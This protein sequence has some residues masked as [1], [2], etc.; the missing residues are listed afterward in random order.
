MQS[1]KTEQYHKKTAYFGEVKL[2]L[3]HLDGSSPCPVRALANGF[4]NS[5]GENE[6]IRIQTGNPSR[7]GWRSIV[8]EADAML[9]LEDF[10]EVDAFKEV[11]TPPIVDAEPSVNRSVMML[12]VKDPSLEIVLGK[13]HSYQR[14]TE[15][16]ATS[17]YEDMYIEIFPIES[18]QFLLESLEEECEVKLIQKNVYPLRRLRI[19]RPKLML[20]RQVLSDDEQKILKKLEEA[21]WYEYPRPPGVS[22]ASIAEQLNISGSTLSIQRRAI[23]RKLSMQYFSD[24][25]R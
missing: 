18:L 10:E 21:G 6:T 5:M 17:A 2:R 7:T 19:A 16:T 3:R 14:L 24:T 9:T 1:E 12:D 20:E 8:V 15:Y 11:L 4:R 22:M 25:R 23:N 13:A